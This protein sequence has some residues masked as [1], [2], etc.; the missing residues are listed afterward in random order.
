MGAIVAK[1]IFRGFIVIKAN[2]KGHNMQVNNNVQ[3]SNFKAHIPNTLGKKSADALAEKFLASKDSIKIDIANKYLAG[4]KK[5]ENSKKIKEAILVT[6]DFG[7]VP[8]V[9][10]DG[11]DEFLG[12]MS[13]S[14][15]EIEENLPFQDRHSFNIMSIIIESTENLSKFIRENFR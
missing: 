7:T 6:S 1:N 10:Y 12:P 8:Y 2:K 4:I 9:K 15:Q 3:T 14:M 11:R 5:L 13:K